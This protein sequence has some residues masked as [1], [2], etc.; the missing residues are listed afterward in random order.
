MQFNTPDIR[1]LLEEVTQKAGTGLD[2][3]SLKSTRDVMIE[4][5][6]N[7]SFRSD[8]LYK[9]ILSKLE[10]AEAQRKVS[11]GLN[12][13]YV[14]ELVQFLSYASYRQFINIRDQLQYPMLESCTGSWYSYV[15]CNSGNPEIYVSPVKIFAEGK[16]IRMLL[17]GPV[18]SYEGVVRHEGGCLY[19]LLESG[20][21]KNLHLVFRL[22]LPQQRPEVLQ[23]VFSGISSAGNPISGREILA[24][25]EKDF[26]QLTHKLYT[27][28][29]L[30]KSKNEK[31]K[32]IGNY[33]AKK[34]K[35]ILSAGNS[36]VF[37]W[38][39]IRCNV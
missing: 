35:A 16:E 15:R 33:F 22:G 1:R 21:G 37:S 12:K 30:C 5:L 6:G 27:I 14:D 11:I 18:R 13:K 4:T 34:E 28:E 26:E 9:D 10:E 32:L 29:E 8:Y 31:A 23:G 19:A 38:S 17:R 36:S 24:R 25:Q 39:D 20:M 3:S 7:V 2:Y